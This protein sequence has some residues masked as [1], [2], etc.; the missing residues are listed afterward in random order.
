M[1]H[2]PYND[3]QAALKRNEFPSGL[4]VFLFYEEQLNTAV[5]TADGKTRACPNCAVYVGQILD[6]VVQQ[7]LVR[8]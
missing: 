4:T 5:V 7:N 2:M 3:I 6:G 8:S 1:Q